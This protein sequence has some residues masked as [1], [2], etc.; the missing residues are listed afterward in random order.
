MCILEEPKLKL[1]SKIEVGENKNRFWIYV[2]LK[3]SL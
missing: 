3:K 1:M 2:H